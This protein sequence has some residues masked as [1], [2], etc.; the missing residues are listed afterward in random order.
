M[1]CWTP[2][3]FKNFDNSSCKKKGLALSSWGKLTVSGLQH[4]HE[5]NCWYQ[6]GA[7]EHEDLD[8]KLECPSNKSLFGTFLMNTIRQARM[9]VLIKTRIWSYLGTRLSPDC[10]RSVSS[11]TWP[12]IGCSNG[13]TF[14]FNQL[15]LE[16]KNALLSRDLI[17]V[18]FLR[19]RRGI[20][21]SLLVF[22]RNWKFWLIAFYPWLYILDQFII[23]LVAKTCL[24]VLE[25]L[26]RLTPI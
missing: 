18:I 24:E 8:S 2:P 23:H 14:E 22:F 12:T 4:K 25:P 19:W 9:L 26:K 7:D 20:K 15:K 16:N 17:Y 11:D 21:I 3:T 6:F 5:Q 1:P 10:G 13:A